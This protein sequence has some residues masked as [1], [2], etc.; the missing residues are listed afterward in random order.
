MTVGDA[1][2]IAKRSLLLSVHL[3]TSLHGRNGELHT[4]GFCQC[5]DVIRNCLTNHMVISGNDGAIL[6]LEGF[7]V[8]CPGNPDNVLGSKHIIQGLCK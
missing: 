2:H 8:G 5:R 3:C 1:A 6:L 4:R 7:E